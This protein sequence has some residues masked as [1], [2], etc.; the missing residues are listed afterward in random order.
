MNSIM[1]QS[2]TN[3]NRAFLYGESVFTT[4]RIHQGKCLFLPDH[5]ERLKKAVDFLFQKKIQ[6][7]LKE[8]CLQIA[9][10][11]PESSL[12]ITYFQKSGDKGILDYSGDLEVDFKISIKDSDIFCNNDSLKLSIAVSRLLENS[13]PTFLKRGNYL[14]SFH[15]KKMAIQNGYD[16]CLFLNNSEE[17]L[18]ASTSNILFRK[19][20]VFFTPTP[21]SVV[22]EG[23]TLKNLKKAMIK[24]NIT[25]IEK[26]IPY[27]DCLSMDQC[28]LLNSNSGITYVEKITKKNFNR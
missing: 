9:A 14:L 15:E 23:I 11:Y 2:T 13:L 25:I 22:L 8:E 21:S 24:K 3:D 18:E 20:E 27:V 4:I 28:W 16:D 17:V 10:K 7:N 1:Y 6:N 19:G 12:R 5:L 26:T